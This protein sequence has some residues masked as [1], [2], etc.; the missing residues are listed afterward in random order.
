MRDYYIVIYGISQCLDAVNHSFNIFVFVAVNLR[1]RSSLVGMF[2]S[3]VRRV[4]ID[5]K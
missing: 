2:N 3:V 4:C 1:F 5:S